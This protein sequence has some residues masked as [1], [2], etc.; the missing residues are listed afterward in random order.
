[1]L[2]TPSAIERRA[3]SRSQSPNSKLGRILPFLGI[4]LAEAVPVAGN[5]IEMLYR[6]PGPHIRR[7][8]SWRKQFKSL[9]SERGQ[10]CFTSGTLMEFWGTEFS[11]SQL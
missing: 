9:S 2:P 10:D 3:S 5:E 6:T 7:E 8:E 4:E 11:R 1:M